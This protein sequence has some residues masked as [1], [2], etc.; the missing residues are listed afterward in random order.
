M[1]WVEHGRGRHSRAWR[2]D[3]NPRRRRIVSSR[4]PM[5][6]ESVEGSGNFDRQV[7]L[8]LERVNTPQLNGYRVVTNRAHYSIQTEPAAQSQRPIGTIGFGGRQGNHWI[9]FTL[10]EFGSFDWGSRAL[11]G[12]GAPNYDPAN[13]T[14]S[15]VRVARGFEATEVSKHSNLTWPFLWTTAG[16]GSIGLQLK[17]NASNLR[18]DV[19][20]DAQARADLEASAPAG[21]WIG[22]LLEIDMQ[23]VPRIFQ[24]NSRRTLQD[25][26]DE[27]DRFEFMD[28][29]DEL[30]AFMPFDYCYSRNPGHGPG[31]PGQRP[32]RK[33]FFR[34]QGRDYA[35][36]GVTLA[37]M[38][39]LLPGEL[40]FDPAVNDS[41]TVDGNDCYEYDNQSAFYLSGYGTYNGNFAGRYGAGASNNVST[42]MRFT[43]SPNPPQ[44]STWTGAGDSAVIRT[45]LHYGSS[46]AQRM[47]GTPNLGIVGDDD[48]NP[49][50]FSSGAEAPNGSG[51][52]DTTAVVTGFNPTNNATGNDRNDTP[53]IGTIVEEINALAN[54]QAFRVRIYNATGGNNEWIQFGDTSNAN[55]T[56]QYFDGY[57]TAPAAGGANL[58][59]HLPLLGVG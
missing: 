24:G 49:P 21:S 12:V 31:N 36:F 16:G 53:D 40:V 19:I 1:A 29:S 28:L 47:A 25:T 57:Y 34:N 6:Y 45:Y 51:F 37:D 43:F 32:I 50:V 27:V 22:G 14:T 35:F 26:D 30:I 13:I 38:Q 4:Q 33:R 44:N 56:D 17:V 39:S 52:V 58:T 9:Y 7:D 23:G 59:S 5:H 54:L 3:V 55:N 18:F 20:V 41:I 48:A 10:S 8:T 42:G 46:A 11:S 2:D 15:D